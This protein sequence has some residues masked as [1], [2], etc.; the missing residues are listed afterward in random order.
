MLD[1]GRALALVLGARSHDCLFDWAEKN[2]N[3][4]FAPAAVSQFF[5]P[6]FYRYYAAIDSYLGV[7]S[8]DNKLYYLNRGV[9]NDEGLASS[10][11]TTTG[12]R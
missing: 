2:Y 7:S 6:Y 5:G 1:A 8:E 9:M 4:Y 12:C 11:Y 3:G 10:W